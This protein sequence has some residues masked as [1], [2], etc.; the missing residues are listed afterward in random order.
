MILITFPSH[1]DHAGDIAERDGPPRLCRHDR[2]G[3][4]A[5]QIRKDA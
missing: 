1:S 5:D 3:G 2:A 4:L